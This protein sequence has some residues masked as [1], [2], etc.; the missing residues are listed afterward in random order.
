LSEPSAKPGSALS[1]LRRGVNTAIVGLFVVLAAAVFAQV[2]A[3]YLFNRPPA[4]TEELARY[5]QVWVIM[6]SASLCLRR[7]SHLAVDYLGPGLPPR[8]RRGLEWLSGIL[9]MIFA[10]VVM[11]HGGRLMLAGRF[12]VSPALGLRMSLVYAVIP[13]S[14]GLMLLEAALRLPALRKEE[15]RA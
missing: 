15:E 4:W 7:G 10:A 8:L 13:L 5:C 3:R 12:Q 14:G 11:V 2:V 9:I 1:A 6:L